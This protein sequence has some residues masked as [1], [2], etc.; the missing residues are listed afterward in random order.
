MVWSS[1]DGHVGCSL[2][3]ANTRTAEFT[4]TNTRLHS[5]PTDMLFPMKR[6]SAARGAVPPQSHV[7]HLQ[8]VVGD[9]LRETCGMLVWGPLGASLYRVAGHSPGKTWSSEMYRETGHTK[10]SQQHL[11]AATATQHKPAASHCGLALHHHHPCC[12]SIHHQYST[13]LH[14]TTLH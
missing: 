4:N 8:T 7:V 6:E 11:N 10:R 13:V 2:N 3:P 14:Y 5:L 9:V 12:H 1:T